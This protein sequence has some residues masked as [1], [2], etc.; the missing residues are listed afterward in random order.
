MK[1]QNFTSFHYQIYCVKELEDCYKNLNLQEQLYGLKIF[2]T[3]VNENAPPY[4][5]FNHIHAT[6][7]I[8]NREITLLQERQIS[9]TK[10]KQNMH[11]KI[12]K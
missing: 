8:T 2:R 7:D 11:T 10:E 4:E 9:L 12:K 6:T 5:L 3:K 1:I